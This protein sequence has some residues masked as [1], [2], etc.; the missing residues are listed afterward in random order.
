MGN[1]F[2]TEY[3]IYIPSTSYVDLGHIG[4]FILNWC[5][6]QCPLICSLLY[7]TKLTL[8]QLIF[9]QKSD[10]AFYIGFQGCAP[11]M[12]YA[13][14]STPT[15]PNPQTSSRSKLINCFITK[16]FRQVCDLSS[17]KVPLGEEFVPLWQENFHPPDY[18][19]P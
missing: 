15:A 3:I 16:Y 10:K 12:E 6:E 19:F 13:L 7:E 5:N 18:L 1:L 17:S 4:V 9:S 8:Y 14:T 2:K 11:R